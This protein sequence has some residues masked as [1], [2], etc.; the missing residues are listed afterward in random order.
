MCIEILE[1]WERLGARRVASE[2][3][4]VPIEKSRHLPCKVLGPDRAP[5]RDSTFIFCSRCAFKIL[6]QQLVKGLRG[7]VPIQYFP[8]A[9][10]EHHLHPL[11]LGARHLREPCPF[12]EELAQQAVG[13]LVG[14]SLSGTM[15]MCKVDRHLHLLGQE[16]V[17]P[18]FGSLVVRERAAEVS[19]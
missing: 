15:P 3:P 18:H 1:R 11:D 4:V 9:S 10:I 12:G 8:W 19:R 14:A 16:A 5:R 13:V 7:T 6:V 17:L 2:K